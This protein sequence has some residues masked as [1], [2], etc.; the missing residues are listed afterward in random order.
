MAED[1]IVQG[2]R[3][4]IPCDSSVAQQSVPVVIL[5]CNTSQNGCSGVATFGNNG[6]QVASFTVWFRNGSA[7]RSNFVLGPGQSHGVH[8]QTGDTWSWV[9]GNTEVPVGAARSWINVG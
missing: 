5:S 2:G 1:A 4:A 7:G 3:E 8:V 6:G 9:W